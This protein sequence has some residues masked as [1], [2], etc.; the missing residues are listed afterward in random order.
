M[1]FK[2]HY[3]K[4]KK[5]KIMFGTINWADFGKGII[6]AFL[7]T[8]LAIIGQAV[9]AGSLPTLAQ[10][11]MAALAGATAGV[12]YIVKNLLSNSEG[13]FLQKEK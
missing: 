7:T 8:F 5:N 13:K 3:Y 11:K 12:G 10:I 2:I 9:E 4:T 1:E 6:V